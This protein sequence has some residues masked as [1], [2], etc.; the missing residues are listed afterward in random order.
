[1]FATI[2]LEKPPLYGQSLVSLSCNNFTLHIFIYVA[3]IYLYTYMN[4]QQQLIIDC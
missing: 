4:N 3:R 1:M 2:K